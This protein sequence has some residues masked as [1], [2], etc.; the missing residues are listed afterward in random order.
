MMVGEGEPP[1]LKDNGRKKRDSKTQNLIRSKQRKA[2]SAPN[3]LG[4]NKQRIR[5]A[6]EN[7]KKQYKMG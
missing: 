3:L 5:S 7:P 1:I 2:V 4:S 6:G